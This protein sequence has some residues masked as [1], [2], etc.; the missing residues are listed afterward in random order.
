MNWQRMA[1]QV[2]ACAAA[3]ACGALMAQPGK[4]PGKRE[5]DSNCA[6]CHGLDGKGKG[7]YVEWLTRSPPDL[8]TMA[9]RNGGV[10][11][12]TRVN[13]VIEGAGPGHGSRDMPIWGQRYSVQAADYYVDVPYNQEAFVRARILWLVE[14]LNRLQAK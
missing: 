2:V 11:P 9:K 3:L 12:I 6:N 5:Y 8:T 4:D 1:R 14:Y 10:Y 7:P 13:D